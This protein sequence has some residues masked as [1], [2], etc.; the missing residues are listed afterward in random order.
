VFVGDLV[1]DPE[2]SHF[3]GPG[4]LAF[5][6]AVGNADGCGIVAVDGGWRLRMSHFFQ[7]EAD[8]FGFLCIE[9]QGTQFG[10]GGGG[11]NKFEDG[12]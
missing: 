6:S 9:K 7:D 10:F 11:G 4:A 5:D 1:D 2:V 12:T 3:H 8:D